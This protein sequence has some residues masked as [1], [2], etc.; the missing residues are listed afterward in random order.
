MTYNQFTVLIKQCLLLVKL[1]AASTSHSR[2]DRGIRTDLVLD[3]SVPGFPRKPTY[4]LYVFVV[5][6]VTGC[7]GTFR[8][9][10]QLVLD[11]FESPEKLKVKMPTRS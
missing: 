7:T 5:F 4:S 8:Y 6:L 3:D 1:Q 10:L 11:P 9:G 2:D